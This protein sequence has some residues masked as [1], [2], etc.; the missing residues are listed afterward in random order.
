M[1]AAAQDKLSVLCVD[2]NAQ[3]AASLRIRLSADSSL[4]WAGWLSDAEGLCDTVARESPTIVILDLEMPGKDPLDALEECTARYPTTRIIVYSI[5][6]DRERI[7][8]AFGAGAWG[9]VSKNDGHEALLEGI[10]AV[11]GGEIAM[12]K[13]VRDASGA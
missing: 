9:Y 7:D 13:D 5:H 4:A 8:R 2:D 10:R 11:L 1:T 12:S 6:T 3:L